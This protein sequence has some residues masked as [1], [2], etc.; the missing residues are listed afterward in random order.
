MSSLK[1]FEGRLVVVS[2]IGLDEVYDGW[3]APLE[4]NA[5]TSSLSV[6]DSS[7]PQITASTQ[8]LGLAMAERMGSEGASV[9][10]SSRKQQAVDEVVTQLRAKGIDARGCACH[11]GDAEARRALVKQT[12]ALFPGRPVYALV[13]NAAVNP[14]T[15]P[16]LELPESAIDKIL[17]I[18][19]KAAIL[20]VKEFMG[21][22]LLVKGSSV[23]FVSSWT[24]FS[25]G[26]PLGIYAVS[27][28][29]LLGLVKALASELGPKGIRVNGL[30]PGL[31]PT[32]FAS[33]L[34]P[35]GGA[36]ELTREQVERINPGNA[37]GRLGRPE[38]Q[39]AA[40]AYLCSEDAAWVTGENLVVAGGVPS[41]L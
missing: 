41:R 1:R 29:A 5:H 31:V 17:D 33:A 28:T 36:Q 13:S 8:G 15:G 6:L 20:L 32:K 23:A 39:A 11:V 2:S 18:N 24:G 40:I 21:A 22:G 35:G 3:V 12:Q 10:I 4:K 37:I 38:D 30:A 9:M 7:L 25:P 26:P 16:V 34:V 14:A 19:V 27:K